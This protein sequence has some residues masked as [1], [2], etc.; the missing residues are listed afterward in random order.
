[1]NN[2]FI[3]DTPAS[4]HPL[5]SHESVPGFHTCIGLDDR[6]TLGHDMAASD[7]MCWLTHVTSKSESPSAGMFTNKYRAGSSMSHCRR[8]DSAEFTS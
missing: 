2:L 6:K 3:D 4:L 7:T 1:M 5:A 8:V